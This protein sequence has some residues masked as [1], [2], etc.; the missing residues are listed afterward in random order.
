[1]HTVELLEDSVDGTGAAAAAHGDV[2]LVGVSVGHCECV[3]DL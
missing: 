2:E 3:W 1:M